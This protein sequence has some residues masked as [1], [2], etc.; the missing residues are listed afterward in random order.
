MT[1]IFSAFDALVCRSALLTIF[2]LLWGGGSFLTTLT[3]TRFGAG[4]RSYFSFDELL[5]Q[6]CVSGSRS[7]ALASN[8]TRPIERPDARRTQKRTVLPT[9]SVFHR[10]PVVYRTG[11]TVNYTLECPSHFGG[12]WN[13]D[14]SLLLAKHR[15]DLSM[16]VLVLK[17]WATSD[18]VPCRSPRC[19]RFSDFGIAQRKFLESFVRG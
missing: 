1:R 13:R 14:A 5:L 18:H 2:T 8:N 15:T 11:L 4:K 19:I 7:P 9:V 6:T 12:R 17:L 16:P 3:P 10:A